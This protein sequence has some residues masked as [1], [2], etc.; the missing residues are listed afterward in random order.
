MI[1]MNILH[2]AGS[3]VVYQVKL[4]PACPATGTSYKSEISGLASLAIKF[5]REQIMN[6]LNRLGRCEA[7][8]PICFSHPTTS[9][10]IA[11]R[12]IF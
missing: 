2:S 5:S 3:V 10:F 4:K 1:N 12:L 6:A 8:F 7:V 9:F 11:C